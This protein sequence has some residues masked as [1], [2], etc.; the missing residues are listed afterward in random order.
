M[1]D[2]TASTIFN[3]LYVIFWL[4]VIRKCEREHQ[5]ELS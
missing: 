5:E 1:G 3:I 2:A 4:I